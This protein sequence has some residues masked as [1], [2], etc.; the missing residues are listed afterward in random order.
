VLSLSILLLGACATAGR[1]PVPP[2][3]ADLA[4]KTTVIRT[5][6]PLLSVSE[7]WRGPADGCPFALGVVPVDSINLGVM[8]YQSCKFGLLVTEG[9]LQ[10]L[11]DRELQAALAHEVGHVLLG[12]F[13][14][15]ETR[16]RSEAKS[17]R[18]IESAGAI[19]SAASAIPGIGPIVAVGAMATEMVA[20]AATRGAY[21]GYDRDEESAADRFAARLMDQIE[22]GRCRALVDL[23]DRMREESKGGLWASWFGEHPSIAS[24]RD[25]VQSVCPAPRPSARR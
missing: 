4:E 13:A 22:P 12:H 6:V 24:R 9:A 2:R 3:Q 20:Q 25:D 21:R 11:E 19:G 7:V 8:P 1:R 14:S 23:F 15:R 10:R 5:L 16:R 17:Q 18:S